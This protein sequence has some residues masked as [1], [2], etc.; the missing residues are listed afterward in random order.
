MHIAEITEARLFLRRP[1]SSEQLIS[2]PLLALGMAI[3]YFLVH[4]AD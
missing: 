1:F 2:L 3:N 4:L